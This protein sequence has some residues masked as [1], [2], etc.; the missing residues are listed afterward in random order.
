[1]TASPR[2]PRVGGRTHVAVWRIGAR[3]P[4][5]ASALRGTTVIITSKG[6]RREFLMADLFTDAVTDDIEPWGFDPAY[7]GPGTAVMP[8]PD[9]SFTVL[10]TP[11]HQGSKK[12]VPVG[13]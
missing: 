13:G 10:G 11:Q 5:V 3:C 4:V 9:V 7:K 8:S 12:Y 1:M 2:S 6:Y